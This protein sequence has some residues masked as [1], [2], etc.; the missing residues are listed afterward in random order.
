MELDIHQ[1][2]HTDWNEI[3][4]SVHIRSAAESVTIN[5]PISKENIIEADD[6]DIRVYDH[7]FTEF[8]SVKVAITHDEKGF[9]FVISGF[10]EELIN[11]MKSSFGDGLTIEIHSY[12]SKSDG[13]WEELKKSTVKTT[14]PCTVR[15]QITSAINAG[16]LPVYVTQ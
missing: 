14:K 13:V 3:K 8:E 4:T 11:G 12:C 9:T 7:Y 15:G 16:K 6:F 10:T 1:Q 2:E 5:L